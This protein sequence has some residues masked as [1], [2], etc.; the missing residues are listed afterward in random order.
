LDRVGVSVD[1]VVM[2]D[3]RVTRGGPG[4]R[5]YGYY[6]ASEEYLR[7]VGPRRA[8]RFAPPRATRPATGPNGSA[9]GAEAPSRDVEPAERPT[10]VTGPSTS[11]GEAVGGEVLAPSKLPAD[12]A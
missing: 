6:V 8:L 11:N 2:N 3:V 12:E 1:A 10:L 7:P 5:A 9:K 4:H